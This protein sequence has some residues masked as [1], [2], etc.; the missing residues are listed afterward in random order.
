MRLSSRRRRRFWMKCNKHCILVS[1]RVCQKI[2]RVD[3]LSPRSGLLGWRCYSCIVDSVEVGINQ[4]WARYITRTQKNVWVSVMLSPYCETT[5][6]CAV[7]QAVCTA[8]CK[9]QALYCVD[10][11][12][13]QNSNKHPRRVGTCWLPT[14]SLYLFSSSLRD[15]YSCAALGIYSFDWSTYRLISASTAYHIFVVN[16]SKLTLIMST[17]SVGQHSD[18]DMVCFTRSSLVDKLL[19]WMSSSD[20]FSFID[21]MFNLAPAT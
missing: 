5:F 16:N 9:S 18:S 2:L 6:S 8:T 1:S 7:I 17:I 13:F 10:W 21:F 3:Q 15:T 4:L 11:L 19:Y 12:Y 20:L 14:F